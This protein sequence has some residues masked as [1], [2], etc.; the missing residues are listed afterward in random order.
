[1]QE[2]FSF[3]VKNSKWFLFIAYV[4]AALALLVGNNPYQHHIYLTSAGAFTSAVYK[5]SNS[6]YSYFDLREINE[7][8]NQR[9]ADLQSQL[10]AMQQQLDDYKNIVLADTLQMPD[11]LKQYDFIVAHVISNSIAKPYNYITLNKGELDGVRPEM[12]V[13]DRNGVVGIVNVVGPHSSRVISLLNSN[14]HIS[15]R[16][17]GNSSFGSLV[18]EGGNPE[19]AEL[20]ELPR[21]TVFQPGDTVVTSGYSGVFPPGIMVGTVMADTDKKNENFFTLKIKLSTDFTTLSN[22]QIVLNH[23]RQEH[24]KL[25]QADYKTEKK[26]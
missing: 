8:L 14:L 6:V 3:F 18:W 16:L 19:V 7:D 17:K 9:N 1:M 24:A 12:G 2:L 5:A 26:R 10:I 22:V 21:H 15:C 11:S 25:E 4:V 13:V 20:Q 23:Q